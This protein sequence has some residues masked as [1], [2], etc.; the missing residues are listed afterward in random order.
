[1]IPENFFKK[2]FCLNIDAKLIRQDNES[3]QDDFYDLM[4]LK[5]A[6]Q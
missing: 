6:I 4:L 2:Y 5:K 1:M 3:L